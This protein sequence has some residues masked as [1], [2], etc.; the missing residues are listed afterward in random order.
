MRIPKRLARNPIIDATTELRFSSAVPTDAVIGLVYATLKSTFGKPE[1]LPILQIPSALREK[2]P[3][4]RYQ[5]CYKFTR[6]GNVLLVGPHNVALGT[7]T[8]VDWTSHS[9]VLEEVLSALTKAGLFSQFERIGLRYINFFDNVNICRHSTLTMAVHGDTITN[10]SLT[11]R[12]EVDS[13]GYKV[14]TQLAN[15]ATVEQG[16]QSKTGSIIDIDVSKDNLDLQAATDTSERLLNFFSA[17]N[18]IADVAFFNL[19]DDGFIK[20]FGP[21]Y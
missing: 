8:Y 15:R 19:L 12:T 18:E 14:V 10:Q 6:P 5:A 21:E 1:N 13:E 3:N 16:G 20:T 4:L 7:T 17:A 9:Q 2:D 11:L